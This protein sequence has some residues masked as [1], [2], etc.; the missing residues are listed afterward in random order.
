[1]CLKTSLKN[2]VLQVYFFAVSDFPETPPPP[3]S[4]RN[5]RLKFKKHNRTTPLKIHVL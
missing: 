2:K 1:M 5:P 4:S 3:K